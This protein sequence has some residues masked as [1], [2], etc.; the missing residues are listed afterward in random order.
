MPDNP[1]TAKK[2]PPMAGSQ[3]PDQDG[4]HDP[5]SSDLAQRIGIRIELRLL[6]HSR[7]CRL[8]ATCRPIVVARTRGRRRGGRTDG[9][10][11]GAIDL[12][13]R[14][15]T[16]GGGPRC[17]RR[18]SFGVR[19]HRRSFDHLHRPTGQWRANRSGLRC[20]SVACGTTRGHESTDA[21]DGNQRRNADPE[22][23]FATAARLRNVVVDR[24]WE[25]RGAA[26]RFAVVI[27][28][29]CRSY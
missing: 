12:R 9:L 19:W 6:G 28:I 4:S 13:L 15:R 22:F 14:R 29:D 26:E 24:G 21:E 11:T 7:F 2:N 23:S 3:P 20:L 16:I 25:T 5:R 8:F 27:K 17:C 18:W 1:F 10:R